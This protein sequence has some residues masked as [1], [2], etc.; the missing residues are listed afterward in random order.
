LFNL[1]FKLQG[2]T[3]DIKVSDFVEKILKMYFSKHVS[4]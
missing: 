1:F 3:I 2:Q 4:G